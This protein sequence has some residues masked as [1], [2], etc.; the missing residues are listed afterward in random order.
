MC[1]NGAEKS[2]T[3][4]CCLK[5]FL[6]RENYDINRVAVERNGEIVPRSVFDTVMLCD[7]DRLEIV[8]FI[9]GG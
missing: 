9:G 1:V 6:E 3:D 2:L 7:S 4:A 8:A 5:E